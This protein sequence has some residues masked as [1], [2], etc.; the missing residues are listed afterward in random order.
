MQLETLTD[1]QG[2]KAQT[3]RAA[4]PR[5]I[6]QKIVD[7][8]EN[9]TSEEVWEEFERRILEPKHKAD[10]LTCLRYWFTNNYRSLA[11]HPSTE[12][13]RAGAAARSAAV[14]AVSSE[15]KRK[16]TSMVQKEAQIVLL[17]M[18]LPHG[19]Q[20]KDSTGTECAKLAPRTDK[21][22]MAVAKEAKG[23][24][25]GEVLAEARLREL[26]EATS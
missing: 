23:S 9:A 22:L 3:R 25:V 8:Y 17:D 7:A 21:F 14:Q 19:K 16:H 12:V 15:I 24:I 5:A 13:D 10:L 26:Y 2:A 6:L 11:L 1:A 4:N 20:L 18:M